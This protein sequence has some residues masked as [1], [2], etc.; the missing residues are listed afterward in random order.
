MRPSSTEQPVEQSD[1]VDAALHAFIAWLEERD[2][3]WDAY[4][5]WTSGSSWGAAL[6]FG[7]YLDALDREGHASRVYET[8]MRRVPTRASA[9]TQLVGLHASTEKVLDLWRA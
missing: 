6:A 5:R 8:A 4:E 2:A 1:A 3:V 9:A 7:A